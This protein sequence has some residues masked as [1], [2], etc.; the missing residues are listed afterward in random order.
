MPADLGLWGEHAFQAV[1]GVV[2]VA[3]WI[4]NRIARVLEGETVS[5]TPNALTCRDDVCTPQNPKAGYSLTVGSGALFASPFSDPQNS[6]GLCKLLVQSVPGAPRV[7]RTGPLLRQRLDWHS[8]EK[9]D[10]RSGK[11][12]EV[13]F[14]A[15]NYPES[16]KPYR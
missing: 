4:L 2:F 7:L 14:L 1:L 13:I 9:P 10:Q 16:P 5:S 6:A 15:R 3:F 12:C 11:S 8:P